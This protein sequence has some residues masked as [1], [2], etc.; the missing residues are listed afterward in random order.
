M[1][2]MKVETGAPLFDFVANTGQIW[3]NDDVRKEFEF[4]EINTPFATVRRK[5]DGVT[6]TL[7]FTSGIP[8]IYFGWK[9]S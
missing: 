8:R 7:E 5:R 1:R 2:D 3:D 6:G 9:E 4:L